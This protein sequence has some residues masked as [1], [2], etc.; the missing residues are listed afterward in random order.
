MQSVEYVN[1][2]K[3][4]NFFK[5]SDKKMENELYI[6][7]E[8]SKKHHNI[9]DKITNEIIDNTL[10]QNFIPLEYDTYF[11]KDSN[12]K[13][14]DIINTKYN[15]YNKN[16]KELKKFFDIF[17]NIYFEYTN[18][19]TCSICYVQMN[20]DGGKL[21]CSHMFHKECLCEWLHESPTCPMCNHNLL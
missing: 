5:V 17:S 1:S 8:V 3:N 13:I 16:Y 11:N 21:M 4:T 18:C 6:N 20:G 12:L 15:Y 14:N 2:L 7:N 10:H 9:K 19:G